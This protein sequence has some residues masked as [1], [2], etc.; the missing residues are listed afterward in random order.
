MPFYKTNQSIPVWLD[1]KDFE[2][3]LQEEADEMRSTANKYIPSV[4][5][6]RQA[7]IALLQA[8]YLNNV[9]AAI[10]AGSEADRITWEYA[11]EVRRDDPLVVNLSATLGLTDVQIDN[12]FELAATI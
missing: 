7:R 10:N 8:G 4:V 5:S 9:T 11:T 2:H 12:L 1:S 6:M 3:L